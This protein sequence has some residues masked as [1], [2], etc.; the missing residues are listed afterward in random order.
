[1]QIKVSKDVVICL[2]VQ[3]YYECKD[4]ASV[5][6]SSARQTVGDL[7]DN[8]GSA[9]YAARLNGRFNLMFFPS[10]ERG[11]VSGGRMRYMDWLNS[12]RVFGI[13][14]VLGRE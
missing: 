12:L 8:R 13:S 5:I 14:T 1:M 2:L 11:S 10:V 3:K 9:S 6:A 4:I 7:H